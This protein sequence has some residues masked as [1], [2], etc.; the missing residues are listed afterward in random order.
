MKQKNIKIYIKKTKILHIH[1]PD[2]NLLTSVL[3]GRP[4]FDW[5]DPHYLFIYLFPY[6]HTCI[7][8]T[9]YCELEG[10]VMKSSSLG[11][12]ALRAH[13]S[14]H[15]INISPALVVMASVPHCLRANKQ[16]CSDCS[17]AP[18]GLSAIHTWIQPRTKLSVSKACMRASHC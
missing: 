9:V 12:Q 10:R 13:K 1:C 2:Y 7:K 6:P 17:I 4:K 18:A 11:F 8:A 16:M 14:T 15:K 3:A 5:F